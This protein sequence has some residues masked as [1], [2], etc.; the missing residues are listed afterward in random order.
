MEKILS[1]AIYAFWGAIWGLFWAF[2]LYSWPVLPKNSTLGRHYRL[3]LALTA[4][5]Y[6]LRRYRTWITVVVGVG[7][8]L[9]I[10]AAVY[11]WHAALAMFCVLAGA[12][13]PV[14]WASLDE[15]YRRDVD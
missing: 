4:K 15:E 6:W 2:L 14:V 1:F 12:G 7:A 11:N 10:F 13:T 8:C 9:L 3:L 5:L